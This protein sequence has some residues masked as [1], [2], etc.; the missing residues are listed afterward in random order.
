MLDL[1]FIKCIVEHG[2]YV[3]EST[4]GG[5]IIIC[6]YVDDLIVT[7]S[8]IKDIEQFKKT[9]EAEFE[10]TDL[11]RLSYFLG[12]EFTYT[13]AGMVMHQK[14]YVG[15]ILKRFNMI[16]CNAVMSPI[17]VNL[18]LTK[19][20]SG[21][22]VNET[23]FKQ[24]VGSLRYLCNNRPDLAYSVGLISRFMSNPKK[25]HMLVAKRLL[26]YIQGTADYGILFPMGQQ[27]T[28]LE[29]VGYADSDYSG[30]LV[31]RKSTSGYL[32]L[33]NDAPVSWCSK[34][35]S[36]V[37]LSSCEA[38]YISGSLAACQGVWLG[39][40][41]KELKI[42]IKAPMELRIDNISAINLSKNPV[43]HGRSKHIEVK[44]H[45]LRDMVNKG[46]ISV[47]YCKTELQL[48]DVFT[49]ALKIE[50]FEDLRRRVGIVSVKHL[51]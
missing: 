38:E 10:M 1:G 48:A 33:L 18:R 43:S 17:E 7:G 22:A 25:S 2:V 13:T 9:M 4:E 15:D 5:L 46:R 21:D 37:A 45:F 42:S 20:E 32:F 31:E 50:R 29:L 28:E 41:L 44:Y 30:D 24:I 40:L 27:K 6:L 3:K 19:D 34:K 26:R 12:M 14:K 47:K 16:S 36:V 51:T 23:K 39:E 49:K 11:G 35:Q 8:N